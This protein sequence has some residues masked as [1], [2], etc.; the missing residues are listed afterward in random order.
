MKKPKPRIKKSNSFS[1]F[2]TSK[3]DLETIQPRAVHSY[4][5]EM[6]D[7]WLGGNFEVAASIFILRGDVTS[8]TII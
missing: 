5:D 1:S 7:L 2:S 8:C 3:P 6:P 4:E